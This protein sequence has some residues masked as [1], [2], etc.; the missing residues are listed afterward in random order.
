MELGSG[1]SHSTLI[2]ALL[3]SDQIK[4]DRV[5]WVNRR[6]DKEENRSEI[7]ILVLDSFKVEGQTLR[8][9]FECSLDG[10]SR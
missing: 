5:G 4:R 2:F 10:V 9:I 8:V 3:R 7:E 1:Y 6:L